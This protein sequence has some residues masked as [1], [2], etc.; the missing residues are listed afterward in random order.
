MQSRFFFPEK[1]KKQ[2]GAPTPAVYSLGLRARHTCAAFGH[3]CV[4]FGPVYL[5]AFQA[6]HTCSAFCFRAYNPALFRKSGETSWSSLAVT[7]FGLRAPFCGQ[8]DPFLWAVGLSVGREL[9]NKAKELLV[10][11][12]VQDPTRDTLGSVYSAGP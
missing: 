7:L 6:G 8:R 10:C 9:S 2:G 11:C 12:C 5:L 4:A 3:I 1:A